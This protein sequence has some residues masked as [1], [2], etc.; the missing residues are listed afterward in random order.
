MENKS[1]VD[2]M[3]PLQILYNLDKAGVNVENLHISTFTKPLEESVE[4]WLGR[5]FDNNKEVF[6]EYTK[7]DFIN[8]AL[9]GR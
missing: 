6:G 1:L 8:N 3:K 4:Q 5:I 9:Y 7:E 2:K